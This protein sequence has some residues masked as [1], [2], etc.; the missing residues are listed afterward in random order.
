M[1]QQSPLPGMDNPGAYPNYEA[2]GDIVYPFIK[3]Q[4]F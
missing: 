4:K 2:Y 3:R 1:E